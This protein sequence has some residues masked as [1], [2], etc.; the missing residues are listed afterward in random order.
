MWAIIVYAAHCYNECAGSQQP[1][2]APCR[3]GHNEMDE[4]RATL[5]LSCAA[6]DDHPRVPTGVILLECLHDTSS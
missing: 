3:H 2:F 1:L 6:I 5:P 4:P